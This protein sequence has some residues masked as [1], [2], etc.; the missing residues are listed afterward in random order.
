[1]ALVLTE[2][3]QFDRAPKRVPEPQ[4]LQTFLDFLESVKLGQ[5]ST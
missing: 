4:K 2:D 5:R 1:M 3:G